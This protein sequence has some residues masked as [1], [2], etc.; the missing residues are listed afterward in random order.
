MQ[1]PKIRGVERTKQ[2]KEK[3]AFSFE[4][5][6]TWLKTEQKFLL[7]TDIQLFGGL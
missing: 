7:D 2:A 5:D 3:K 1:K 6:K 4:Y